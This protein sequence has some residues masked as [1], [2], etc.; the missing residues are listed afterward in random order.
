MMVR[1]NVTD[2]IQF[3]ENFCSR[4]FYY[5]LLTTRTAYIQCLL[6]FHICDNEMINIS[7]NP[8]TVM[9]DKTGG[10]HVLMKSEFLNRYKRHF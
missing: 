5:F 6:A 3:N 10:L 7:I 8:F 1:Q 9:L 2:V 4:S